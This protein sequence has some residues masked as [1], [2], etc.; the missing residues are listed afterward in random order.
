MQQLSLLNLIAIFAFNVAF[1][2]DAIKGGTG[3]AVLCTH[4]VS[5]GTTELSYANGE[6]MRLSCFVL[7][8]AHFNLN[9]L[10]ITA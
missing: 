6:I 9:S 4:H 8:S 2:R 1:S 5:V 3:G 10:K 7:L